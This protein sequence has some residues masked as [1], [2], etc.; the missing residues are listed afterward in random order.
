MPS[1]NMNPL[2]PQNPIEEFAYEL[3]HKDQ[4]IV[5]RR[6]G[7]I[8][9]LAAYDKYVADLV[10]GKSLIGIE[11]GQPVWIGNGSRFK[12]IE[13]E[14]VLRFKTQHSIVIFTGTPI[15]PVTI[16]LTYPYAWASISTSSATSFAAVVTGSTAPLT[17]S[18]VTGALPAGLA[19]NTT[20]GLVSG[21]ATTAS[22]GTV[23]IKVVDS[24]G[25]EDTSPVY[26]WTVSAPAVVVVLTYPYN[27]A[28]ITTLMPT[29]FAAVVTGATSPLTFS[30]V[31]G[32]LPSGLNLNSSSGLV[33]G[34]ASMFA[35]G[36]SGTI[37]IK[38]VDTN[39]DE[40][41]SPTYSWNV[42]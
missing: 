7:N 11:T 3:W 9:R 21:T 36:T 25:D 24:N 32:S 15:V 31:T 20:T 30:I 27:W 39:G 29:N 1:Q 17:F 40:D 22:S 13:Y 26:S 4:D 33:Y 23:S 2:P 10:E 16:V 19:L 8:Q 28:N 14:Q 34:T 18:I 41:T 37:A 38:V 12:R 35:W 42:T 5:R 6:Q